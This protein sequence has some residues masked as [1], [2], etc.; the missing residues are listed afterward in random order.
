LIIPEKFDY[1]LLTLD[2]AQQVQTSAQRIRRLVEQTLADMIAVGNELLAMK[3]TLPHGRFG[4]WLHA[5]FGWAERTARYF[6]TVAVRFGSKPAT[7]ADL[8]IEP[9][10]AYLLAAPS[11]PEEASEEAVRRAENGEVITA[12]IAREILGILKNKPAQGEK[13]RSS[14]LSA[15]KLLGELLESLET[16]RRRWQPEQLSLLVRELRVFA[17]SLEKRKGSA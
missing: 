1:T 11:A 15:R 3:E 13:E 12:D 5:E 7:L 2:I 16:F 9:T 10:A 8:P 6:M 14:A 17:D 4:P